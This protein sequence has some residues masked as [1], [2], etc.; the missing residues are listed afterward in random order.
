MKER[1]LLEEVEKG[2]KILTMKKALTVKSPSMSSE[3]FAAS[4]GNSQEQIL[5]D[6]GEETEKQKQRIKKYD[7]FVSEHEKE[8]VLIREFIELS[9]NTPGVEAIIR[10]FI[11]GQP[12][13]EIADVMSYEQVYTIWKRALDDLAVILMFDL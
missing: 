9:P 11:E 4:L 6:I 7:A 1:L 12:F 10:H 13:R 8:K 3:V 2:Q 5:I